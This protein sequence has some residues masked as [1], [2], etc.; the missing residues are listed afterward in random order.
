[1]ARTPTP[2]ELPTASSLVGP[3]DRRRLDLLLAGLDLLDQAIAVFDATPKLV[4]WNRAMQR[5]LDFPE[6]LVHEGTPFEAFARFNAERGE[7]GEGDIER[8]VAERVMAA[9]AFQP[10]YFERER[11]NGRI[12][13]VRGV[14]IPNLGFVSL[15][16]DI[17]EQRRYERLIEEQNQTLE[18]R[19]AERTA[20][21]ARANEELRAA[22]VELDQTAE[23][24]RRSEERLR[25]IL[26]SIPAMVAYL[27]ADERYRF[28]NRVYAEWFGLEQDEIVGRPVAEITGPDTYTQIA[29]HL[30]RAHAG[31]TVSYE[32]ARRNAQGRLVHARSTVVPECD[33]HGAVVGFFV[34]SIDITEQKA[35]QNALIQ[36]QK[37]EA[38]GQLTGGVAHDFNNLLTTL[39]GNLEGLKRYLGDSSA[40]REYLE[41]AL[42]ASTRGV[43]LIRRLLTFARSQPL[44]PQAVEVG[45]LVRSMGVILERTLGETIAI[46]LDLPAAP[47]YAYADAHQL[48]NALLNLALNARDAMAE[49]G[50]TLTIRVRPW[51]RDEGVASDIPVGDYVRFDVSDTGC[52]MAPEQLTRVFEPFYTTKPFGQ[53]SGLGLAMVYGFVRQSGGDIQVRSEPGRGTTFSFALP[54]APAAADV[55]GANREEE[56]ETPPSPPRMVLLVEDELPV[57]HVL[58]QQL[59]ALGHTVL[60]AANAHEAL[61][62]LEHVEEIELL[63]TDAVMPGELDGR[64]L[65]ARA[66]M[67]RSALPTVLVTG[68]AHDDG[69]PVD[70]YIVLPKPCTQAQL[71]RALVAAQRL[72]AGIPR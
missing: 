12:L 60:E 54:L 50:G 46:V 57:R 8:L 31:K 16:T 45:E 18:A 63:V 42:A 5:L 58:R 35:H 66:R 7:Y 25:L 2:P 19:V 30:A 67:L 68:Y 38:I 11:P 34:L 24:L 10:H 41:P 13:A 56:A 15:W 26:D 33:E 14:P 9:R 28:A 69:P 32:Y 20:A 22:Q 6:N 55:R 49:R 4:A 64:R 53:G 36:A 21:L 72:A 62:L 1:M 43:A 40:V 65:I 39:I 47:L 17:T 51:H 37:M 3:G 71:S 23:A 48:E 52:G 59:M 29:A 61:E 70:G 27:D 44:A